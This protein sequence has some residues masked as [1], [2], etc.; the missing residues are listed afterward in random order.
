MKK[1]YIYPFKCKFIELAFGLP[2]PVFMRQFSCVFF[3][4]LVFMATSSFAEKPPIKFGDVSLEELKM[5]SF[6]TDTSAPAVILCDYGYF[7]SSDFSFTQLTR[8][9]ILKKTGYS[10][11]NKKFPPYRNASVKGITHNLVN[12]QIVESKLESGSIYTE[13]IN[14][15]MKRICISMPNVKV[16]SVIDI[17]FVYNGIPNEWEFQQEI[18]VRH[19]ELI[20][21][22]SQYVS[23]RKNFSGFEPLN[24]NEDGHWIAENMPAFKPEPYIS[25]PQ[26]Y[27]TR[28]D[29]DIY[30]IHYYTVYEAFTTT[31]EAL[32]SHLY[33]NDYFGVP[34][35]SDSY[36]NHA[37]KEIIAKAKTDKDKLR[38]AHEFIKTYKWNK[39]ESLYTSESN[40]KWAFDKKSGNSADINLAL[41][42]LLNKLGLQAAPVLL[43]TRDNGFLSP[44]NPSLNKLNY[45]IARVNLKG[46]QFL[47]DATEENAP[48][49]L[50]PER[51]LNLFGRLYD[52]KNSES[53]ELK[54]DK[55]EKEVIF[56]NLTIDDDLQ[57]NGTMNF[58]RSDYAA[59]D[60][61]NKYKGFSSKE[62]YL[63]NMLGEFPGLRIRNSTIENVDSLSLPVKDQFEIILKNAVDEIDG[64]LYIYPMMLHRLKENPFKTDKRKYPID[65]IHQIEKNYYVT[66]NLPENYEVTSFPET[67][68]MGLPGND[69]YFLYQVK[70][71]GRS[72]QF[73][74]KIGINKTIFGEDEYMDIREFYNQILA[75]H[76]EPIILKKNKP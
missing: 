31:W 42:Q 57:I 30:D 28:L 43:S 73:N 51:D 35:R 62:S 21:R 63:E 44:V 59:L 76:A 10:W 18:P 55:K 20:M 64:N 16:G 41:I 47:M 3:M 45:V 12:G 49:D 74:F 37:A 67:I 46:E 15:R 4:A 2:N 9:K 1:L 69:A 75:K 36:L 70:V 7:E 52:L 39:Y 34:L 68:K 13:T 17:K 14:G 27:L 61:R 24:L 66:I 71:V 33:D 26:N 40:I 38:L 23:F 8:I 50:L 19:S 54:T 65:F 22:N 29:F 25:S 56:Y 72:I 48:Y 32:S 53:V 5:T 11:A 58:L 6:E 60:F